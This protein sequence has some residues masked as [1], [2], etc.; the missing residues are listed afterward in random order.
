IM[1]L[2]YRYIIPSIIV[3]CI[4]IF[5][6]NTTCFAQNVYEAS[7][8]HNAA[9]RSQTVQQIFYQRWDTIFSNYLHFDSYIQLNWVY[10]F[11][12]NA[13]NRGT[14]TT[15]AVPMR[16]VRTFSDVALLFSV[17]TPATESL[18][19]TQP[20]DITDVT[21]FR[22]PWVDNSILLGFTVCGY[23][24]GLTRTVEINRGSAGT[25]SAS[26]YAFS[27]FF[28]DIVAITAV[29]VP[30]I[31][32]H[33][34][35]VF[36]QQIEPNEDGTLNY[37]FDPSTITKRYFTSLS[38]YNT[39]TW[40]S[41]AAK[42]RMESADVSLNIT[43]LLSITTTIP[44]YLPQTTIGYKRYHKYNDEP[45]DPVWVDTSSGKSNTM[46]NSLKQHATLYTYYTTLSKNFGNLIVAASIEIQHVDRTLIDKR[47]DKTVSLPLMR[48]WW[49]K[50][51]YDF[52]DRP[53]WD[54]IVWFGVNKFYDPAMNYH[55]KHSDNDAGGWFAMIDGI[56]PYIT[57]SIKASYNDYSELDKLI[58]AVDKYIVEGS[59]SFRI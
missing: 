10:D 16:L 52:M 56:S 9:S 30:S 21:T 19:E 5:P 6:L 11:Y 46:S 18:D 28:D 55:S 54:F 4:H 26:D 31:T 2:L 13:Y 17:Y 45:Y 34:G 42:D 36:N 35:I 22:K 59:A 15:Q 47:T 41:T 57:L 37:N 14:G 49:T 50:A 43:Q 24:Y 44:A 8:L 12:V 23:H 32:I 53:G 7:T 39:L 48:L 25:E 58:E 51:G 3:L 29:L 27:Q 40:R 33:A 1:I 38:L 20:V